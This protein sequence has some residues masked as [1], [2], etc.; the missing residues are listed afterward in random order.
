MPRLNELE[1]VDGKIWANVWYSNDIVKISP[2]D[3][4]I[5]RSY[6][7]KALLKYSKSTSRSN[8]PDVLNGIAYNKKRKTFLLTGKLW[9]TVFEVSFHA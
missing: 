8:N 6:D 7:M 2:L 3:G 1:Y 9:P 5:E 4:S